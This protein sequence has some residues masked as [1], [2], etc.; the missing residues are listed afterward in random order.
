MGTGDL[1]QWESRPS[2]VVRGPGPEGAAKGD[3]LRVR[4]RG[5]LRKTQGGLDTAG[6]VIGDRVHRRSRTL[7]DQT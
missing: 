2:G 3:S 4:H 1:K 6:Y 5:G 7:L